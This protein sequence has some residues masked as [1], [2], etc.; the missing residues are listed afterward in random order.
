MLRKVDIEQEI[1][2]FFHRILD[3]GY[4]LHKIRPIF[5]K[6]IEN[7][8][9]NLSRTTEYRKY[10][11]NKKKNNRDNTCSITF[12]TTLIIHPHLPYSAYGENMCPIQKDKSHL[13][14]WKTTRVI[15]SPSN[16]LQSVT[17]EHQI[18]G[19]YYPIEK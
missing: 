4:Q 3:R 19:T 7:V 17:A 15:P 8:K 11:Q 14:T 5:A 18:W 16:N 13:T 2:L 10:L 9:R 12:L 6:A 1:R